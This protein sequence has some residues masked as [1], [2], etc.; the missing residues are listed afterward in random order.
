[1]LEAAG[2]VDQTNNYVFEVIPMIA[3]ESVAKTLSYWST[4]NGDN[5]MITLWNPADEP[6]NLKFV[7]SFAGGDGQYTV[8]IH[9]N[10]RETCSF[11]ISTIINTPTPD[12][13]GNVIP[14]G[15]HEGRAEIMGANGENEHILIAMDEGVYNVQKA[16]CQNP[17][18]QT[19]QGAVDSWISANPFYVPTGGSTNLVFT[20]QY[21]SG[22]KYNHTSI[23]GWSSSNNSIA[24]V[25]SGTVHG[26]VSGSV[27]MTASDEGVPD[28]SYYCYS[29]DP[30]STCPTD[31]GQQAEAP[32][33]SEAI[34]VNFQTFQEV[35]LPDGTLQF[36]YTWQSSTGNLADIASCLVGETVYYP[37]TTDPYVWPTPMVQ[38][39]RNPTPLYVPGNNSGSNS[40]TAGLGDYNKPP[41]SYSKPY[42]T[43]SFNATQTLQ[44]ECPNYNGGNYNRFVPDITISRAIFL[45]TD[46]KWKYTISKSG[47]ANK[48]TLPNQ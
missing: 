11:N 42:S 16:T 21:K 19:C 13:D 5:T 10:A 26:L 4:G 47:Y 30:D 24:T 45:D 31:T 36:S 40:T 41:A 25:S 20:V 37:G 48:A 15:T 3:T 32:G 35:P 9:L 39:T 1:M 2:S 6:Q 7:L 23:A 38:Q 44:W 17:Y 29:S 22:T 46:G 43:A 33:N 28:Y 12:E 18:C 8:P 14:P 27:N 34:P